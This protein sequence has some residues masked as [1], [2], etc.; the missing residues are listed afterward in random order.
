MI[1]LARWLRSLACSARPDPRGITPPA[2]RF[3]ASLVLRPH[4]PRP[5]LRASRCGQEHYSFER[6]VKDFGRDVAPGSEDA[7]GGGGTGVVARRCWEARG[8]R[9]LLD[10]DLGEESDGLWV[11][12]G[13]PESESM[14]APSQ[15][16]MSS[17]SQ[18]PM[19]SRVRI[20]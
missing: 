4:A 11:P 13:F 5:V 18:N 3:L 15:N 14:G 2:D 6:F 9:A 12:E 17:Q 7:A 16:P 8:G 20:R 1:A 19:G 10:V